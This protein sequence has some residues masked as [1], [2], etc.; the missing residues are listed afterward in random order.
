MV[1][2]VALVRQ[3]TAA[4]GGIIFATMNAPTKMSGVEI[5]GAAVAEAEALGVDVARACE[6]GLRAEIKRAADARGV[7]ENLP[8]MDAWNAWVEEHGL[9][10]AKYRQF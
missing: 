5:D 2:M 6:A 7:E 1:P 9:P 8:A 4:A 3:L 10:L